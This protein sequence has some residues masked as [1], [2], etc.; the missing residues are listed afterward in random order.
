MNNKRCVIIGGA[1]I[2]NYQRIKEK[3]RDDD[4]CIFCDC[5]LNHQK[6]LGVQP[7]LI[8]GDFDSYTQEVPEQYA[9]TE[10][11][12]LPCEK[13]DT[14][15]VYAAKEGLKRGFTDFFLIGAVGNR[16]DHSL[17]NTA[18]LLMLHNAGAHGI[19]IDDYSEMEVVGNK[20]IFI[21]FSKYS[22]VTIIEK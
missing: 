7:A 13:Y 4:F 6:E 15:T 1:E 11:I 2:H 9:Q 10:I 14:D 21:P 3:L 22:D 16:F 8:I 5:G 19:L 18:I 17:A 12:R 20:A